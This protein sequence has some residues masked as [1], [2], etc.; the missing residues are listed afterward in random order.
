MRG[1]LAPARRE[2]YL[3]RK[4]AMTHSILNL[5]P[6]YSCPGRMVRADL[7]AALIADG[8]WRPR[9]LVPLADG[10]AALVVSSGLRI[11]IAADGAVPHPLALPGE[12]L[13]VMAVGHRLCVMFPSGPSVYRI[14]GRRLLP[15]SDAASAPEIPA[16]ITI[17]AEAAPDVVAYVPDLELSGSYSGRREL[18]RADAARVA[19][20][21]VDVYRACDR[22]ARASGLLWQ[23]VVARLRFYRSDGSAAFDSAPVLLTHP[24]QTP[25][26]AA[27]AFES[28]DGKVVAGGARSVRAWRVRIS[29]PALPGIAS[30][31]LMLS[32][33]LQPS[34]L[35][36]SAVTVSETGHDGH[37]CTAA[38]PAGPADLLGGAAGRAGSAAALALREGGCDAPIA[39][40]AGPFDSPSSL[41]PELSI[42]GDPDYDNSS[43]RAV[44]GRVPEVRDDALADLLPPNSFTATAFAM[45][46]GKAVWGGLR[47]IP[48]AGYAPDA[49]AATVTDH[50]W[51]GYCR[52][53]LDDGSAVVRTAAA[54]SGAPASLLPVLAVSSSR[55]RSLEIGLDIDGRGRFFARYDLN[56][57]I[58][59]RGAAYVSTLMRP[60]ELSATS[61]FRIPDSTAAA[62]GMEGILAVASGADPFTLRAAVAA[63]AGP[64]QALLPAA[65]AQ[66]SWDFGRAR[67]Y[68]FS[69]AG[70]HSVAVGRDA[71]S[72]SLALLDPRPCSECA[73]VEAS[74][75]VYAL[76]GDDLVA[77]RGSRV[78]TL[79]YGVR[80]DSLLYDGSRHELWGLARDGSVTVIPLRKGWP[81]YMLGIDAPDP[82]AVLSS[83]R[84]AWLATGDAL[85]DVGRPAA[86]PLLD[87]ALVYTARL[88]RAGAARCLSLDIHGRLK[89]A[90][91]EAS[92]IR[93]GHTA[94][95]PDLRLRFDADL[96]APLR[97]PFVAPPAADHLITLR[98]QAAPGVSWQ[99]K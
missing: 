88:P 61:D 65:A 43:L 50:A 6:D 83:P 63:D 10:S 87:I 36:A 92:R 85:L 54:A 18:E 12:P 95:A 73:P 49:F 29:L 89:N 59:R 67:F 57:D 94:T 16:G 86:A 98:A 58:S 34:S 35:S 69:A 41:S 74:G 64:V 75:T 39:T 68:S 62:R 81:D 42:A 96:R 9:A 84:G 33:L 55:S 20:Y 79:R 15:E 1:A 56:P 31:R 76:A 93:H 7:P 70:I 71:D 60:M 13:A 47:A 44:L 4:K 3:C 22:A 72:L 77:L 21:A 66:S 97:I 82:A 51:R 52:I 23:P 80:F 53:I 26:G 2:R 45:A 25:D 48:F 90:L 17:V 24:T 38:M 19:A 11:G 91:L 28:A 27:W 30:A 46:S 37:F 78:E 32:P 40:L 8:G 99:M 14:D 5:R